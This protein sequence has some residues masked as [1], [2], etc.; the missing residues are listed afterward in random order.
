VY[1][2]DVWQAQPAKLVVPGTH[3]T[4]TMANLS[5]ATSYHF[6]IIAENKL[7][8]GEPG[9]VIQVTTQEEGDLQYSLSFLK[10]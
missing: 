6:R 2:A 4:A 7:G 9:E 8:L 10:L 1:F 3:T 5:P